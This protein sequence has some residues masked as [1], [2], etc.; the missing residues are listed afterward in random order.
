M[1][2]THNFK[3]NLAFPFLFNISNIL[4]FPVDPFNLLW[5]IFNGINQE[6]QSLCKTIIKNELDLPYLNQSFELAF[7]FDVSLPFVF[8]KMIYN[9]GNHPCE[10]LPI[11]L[12]GCIE[13]N[14]RNEVNIRHEI[15]IKVF[16]QLYYDG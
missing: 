8:G 11:V 4:K 15:L 14:I 2:K 3:L 13:E 9:I 1:G 5:P 6:R 16:K 12:T 10:K 7:A